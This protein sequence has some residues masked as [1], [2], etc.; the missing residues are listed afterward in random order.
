M[1]SAQ[2]VPH[3]YANVRLLDAVPA[4]VSVD[5]AVVDARGYERL[6]IVVQPAGFAAPTDLVATLEILG[7]FGNSIAG[8]APIAVGAGNTVL[9]ALPTGFTVDGTDGY[10][11][12]ATFLSNAA[13][14]LCFDRCPPSFALRFARTSGGTDATLTVDAYLT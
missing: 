13:I 14:L 5:S 3:G 2:G 12:A 4:T 1:Q 8:F 10:A 11:F 7:G 9:G 6:W